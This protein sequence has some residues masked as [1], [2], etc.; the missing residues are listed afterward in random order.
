MK[1]HEATT[2]EQLLTT[3][4]TFEDQWDQVPDSDQLKELIPDQKV[5]G[6]SE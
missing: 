6:Y 3:T 4:F 5:H 2:S 1:I